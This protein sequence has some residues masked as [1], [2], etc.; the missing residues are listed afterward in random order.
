VVTLSLTSNEDGLIEDDGDERV[1]LSLPGY[2]I[3]NLRAN[4]QPSPQWEFY[5][6]VNNATDKRSQSFGAL[7]ETVFNANGSFNGVGR[8]AVFIGPG[9]PRSVFAGLRLRF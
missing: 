3:L 2:A 5:L 1:D 8:D 7:A 9:A 4:W 6:T